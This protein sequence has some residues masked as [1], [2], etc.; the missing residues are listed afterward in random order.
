[1]CGLVKLGTNLLVKLNDAEERLL[2]IYALRQK[3]GEIDPKSHQML[4]ETITG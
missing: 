1:M 3:V 2:V 4:A